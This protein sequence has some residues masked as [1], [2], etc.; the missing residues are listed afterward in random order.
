MSSTP[1]NLK[2]TQSHEWVQDNGDGTATVG[3]TDHAQE[4]LGDLVFVELP[5]VGAI[6]EAGAECAVVESVKAASDVYAPVAGEIA[7]VNDALVGAPETIN[8]APYEAGWIFKIRPADA[9]SL[10][11]LMT[12]ADYAAHAEAEDN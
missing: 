7:A 8:Q 2:Y 10:D 5:E 4:L 9:A 11:R 6:Y 1:E 12:A 3:I